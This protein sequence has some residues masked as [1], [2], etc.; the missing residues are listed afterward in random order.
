MSGEEAHIALVAGESSGDKIGAR[1]MSALRE[2]FPVP[3]RFSGFG[4]QMMA[5]AGLGS[6]SP[7]EDLS[8]MGLQ[9]ILFNLRRIFHHIEETASAIIEDRPDI[10]VI[11]DSPDFTHRVAR[12][13]HRGAPEIPIVNYIP[14]TAW[15][16]RKGR[17]KRIKRYIRAAFVIFPFE[18]RLFRELDGPPTFY[19]GPPALES[20]SAKSDGE[21]FRKRHGLSSSAKIL[22]LAPGSRSRE[23]IAA[24]PPFLDAARRLA[25]HQKDLALVLCAARSVRDLIPSDLGLG[26]LR[27]LVIEDEAEKPA[28]FAASDAALAVMGTIT[29]EL[30][31]AGVPLV[32]AYRIGG[33]EALGRLLM[34]R[35]RYFCAVNLIL[36][37]LAFPE[38]IGRRLSAEVFAEDL[39]SLL[40]DSERRARA[41]ADL[42]E[43][44]AK[45][46]EGLS[47]TPSRNAAGEI[48][49]IW[50]EWKEGMETL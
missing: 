4:G 32:S 42:R 46:M 11:I 39:G 6:P 10:L 8:V 41:E 36:D 29:M 30:G 26:S 15:A 19:V 35:V 34:V 22:L 25:S 20:L 43:M 1:L 16:W 27:C 31:L 38:H 14:P 12:R 37:R 17:A 49:K 13:V 33:L 45:I 23:I 47:E 40:R 24:L 18:P 3:V 9:G 44:R 21:D 28:A 50:K 7:I 5:E 48:L 2:V